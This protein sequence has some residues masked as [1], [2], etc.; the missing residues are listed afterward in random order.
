MQLEGRHRYR[1]QQP[2]S[3]R[4]RYGRAVQHPV[5]DRAPDATL[6]VV[7]T[8]NEANVASPVPNAEVGVRRLHV[9]HGGDHGVGLVRCILG[10]PGELELNQ[11]RSPVL[12]DQARLT[13]GRVC[14]QLPS[15]GQDA[16]DLVVPLRLGVLQWG[17]AVA[18]RD[19]RVRTGG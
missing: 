11:R 17:D 19:G 16:G 10:W 18:V 1:D 5:D 12:G 14:V 2:A 15:V 3:Q 4:H 6:A 8:S 9:S 7:A 13:A